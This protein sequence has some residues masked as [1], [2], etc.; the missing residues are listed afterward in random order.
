MDTN[1]IPVL[2]YREVKNLSKSAVM[3]EL[4]FELRQL[5]FRIHTCNH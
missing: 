1:I 2:M 3:S 4:G 5:G